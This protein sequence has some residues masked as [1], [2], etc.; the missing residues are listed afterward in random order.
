[1][2]NKYTIA[3]L[4]SFLVLGTGCPKNPV[5]LKP[6]ELLQPTLGQLYHFGQTRTI[7]WRVNDKVKIDAIGVKLSLDS[8]KTFPISIDNGPIPS[9]DSVIAWE[10]INTQVSTQ[11]V[12]KV[13]KYSDESA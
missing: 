6:I 7:K 13:F 2:L 11:C 1:M 10:I 9:S 4:G 3:L 8:G 5:S 12:I